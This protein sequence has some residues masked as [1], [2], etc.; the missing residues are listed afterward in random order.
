LV[1]GSAG[2]ATKVG[3][4]KPRLEAEKPCDYQ[5]KN[6]RCT[7]LGIAID[8]EFHSLVEVLL[9]NGLKP[10]A[11]HLTFAIRKGNL[12]IVQLL[13]EHGQTFGG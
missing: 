11:K 2:S 3:C 5:H 4:S 1:R 10:N 6:V 9:R 8:R 13:L 7:P 12:G